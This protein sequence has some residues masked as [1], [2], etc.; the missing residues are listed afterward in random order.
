MQLRHY[1][2]KFKALLSA[3]L[4]SGIRKVLGQLPT[5]GGKTVCFSAISYSYV[6]KE[7]AKAATLHSEPAK[8]VLIL[9]HRKELLQQTRKTL[10]NLYGIAA[11]AIVAGVKYI[12]PAEVYV[13][14]V[15]S[16]GRRINRIKNIGL[17]IIDEAHIAAFNK[18]HAFFPTQYIIGVTATPKSASKKNPMKNHYDDIVCSIDIPELIELGFLAQNITIAPKEVVSRAELAVKGG[19]FQDGFMAEKFSSPKYIQSTIHAYEKYAKDKKTIVFNVTVDHSHKVTAAFRLA[20]YNCRHIDGGTPKAE[21]DAAFQ[22]LK[23]TPDA[24]LCN[25]GIATTGF[26]EPTIECVIVNKATMSMPL[27]LQMAG[28]GGRIT[29]SKSAF[30]IIDMGGNAITHGDWC[31]ARDWEDIFKNPVKPGKATG[32]APVKSCTN[33]DAIIAA[34]ARVCKFCGYEYPAAEIEDEKNV[35]KDFIVVTKGINVREVIEAHK[36]KK[37]Y[38][39]FFQIGKQVASDARKTVPSMGEKELAVI[40]EHYHKVCRDWCHEKN[41]KYNQWHREK[42]EENLYV[43]L[44]RLYPKWAPPIQLP[45]QNWKKKSLPA[46]TESTTPNHQPF[47]KPVASITTQYDITL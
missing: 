31:D 43:E 45:E 5:G 28:R 24:I 44:A 10:Y 12:P 20:G 16:V 33:C 7:K 30:T 21:R 4:A 2:E 41:K 11:H 1:Q 19:E 37:D 40:L 23:N 34:S 13:G 47:I 35:M 27:W 3:K 22:W 25:V 29:D 9:V 14:M 46:L 8:S 17:V 42:A 38:Y 26:D 15:E 36:D 18:I 6:Q 39:S 32:L